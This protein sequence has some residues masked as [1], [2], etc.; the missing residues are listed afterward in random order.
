MK[1]LEET[2]NL[3][4]IELDMLVYRLNFSNEVS[5]F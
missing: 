5:I 1:V 2:F 3:L 4:T